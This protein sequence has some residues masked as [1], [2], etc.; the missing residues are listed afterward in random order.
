MISHYQNRRALVTGGLGFIGSN[1]SLR[2]A[3]AGSRVTVVDSSIAGC[4][5]NPRNL[6]AA[7]GIRVIH[8]DIGSPDVFA[9]EIRAADI[10]FNLAGEVSHLHSM[11]QPGRDAELN[12]GAQ[13]RFLDGCARLSPGLRVVYASTRQIYGAPRYL[14]VDE[15]HPIQPV[16][17]NGIH[18]YA[19]TSYHLLYHAMGRLD[20][21]VLCLT[22]VYG[23]RMALHIPGQGFL[24]NFLRRVLCGE[25]LEV[26]GDGRQL[27][28]PV[29]VDDAVNA[30]LV[31]GAVR[32]PLTRLWNVGGREALSLGSIAC[33][34]SAAAGVAP[35]V[36]RPFP[37]EHKSIDIGSYTT[38][39]SRI[40]RDLG[41]RPH[42]GFRQGI[43]RSLEFFRREWPHYLPGM[44]P[45]A[46]P[47]VVAPVPAGSIT[48]DAPDARPIAV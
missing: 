37:P 20:T 10:V 18:K 42:V 32:D 36:F 25:S 28:D 23:P 29:F 5:A 44:L 40:L 6:E 16:D 14:P 35:P 34:L 30:F 4:G 15:A 31:A 26:F 17:F 11:R 13:L 9:E 3:A 38:D 45:G 2:L 41:W 27:R 22:N 33:V 46:L 8:C 39:S 19:A 21:R 24:G 1:L 7:S 48:L 47:G 43:A 12:A